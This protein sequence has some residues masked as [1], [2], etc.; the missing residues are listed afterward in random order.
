MRYRGLLEYYG[1]DFIAYKKEKPSDK[2]RNEFLRIISKFMTHYIEDDCPPS[3]K[4]CPASFWELF[5]FSF[6][7]DHIKLSPTEQ[8]VEIFLYQLKEFVRW[9]DKRS[10]TSW[11]PIIEQYSLEAFPELKICERSINWIFLRGFPRIHHNDWN[12]EQD[13]MYPATNMNT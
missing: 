12:L 6:Y 3:W 8:E 2:K 7:P 4:Q 9:L 1:K 13:H 5:I 10:G 11:S